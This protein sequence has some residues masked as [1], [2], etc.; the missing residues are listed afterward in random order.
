MSN[1]TIPKGTRDFPPLEMARRNYIF[2]TIRNVF[3]LFGYEPIETPAMENLSTLLGKYGDEGD[4]LIFKVLNSGNF[5]TSANETAL[6]EKILSDCS[7]ISAKRDYVTIL[8][9]PS[10]GL[11]SST[12][13]NLCSLS[14]G[15][16][17]S[18]FGGPT[19]LRKDVTGN[20]TN[21]M[22]M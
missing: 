8:Q 15:S 12:A 7:K 13:T 3:R 20:F 22:W 5:L 17:Y 6:Q 16:R 10:P 9:Y 14:N 2:D 18:R 21:A 19:G 11:L 1:P 4:K